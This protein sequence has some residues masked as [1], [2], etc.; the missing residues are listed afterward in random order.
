MAESV[1]LLGLGSMGK[2][3]GGALVGA[4]HDV[5]VW[6]RG[7][8]GRAAFA[9]RCHVAE[10]PAAAC[11]AAELVLICLSN[12]AAA[13]EVLEQPGV[14]A[15]LAGRTLVQLSTATPEE[16]RKFGAWAKANGTTYLDAKIAVTPPQIGAPMT[17]IFY[18]GSRAAFGRYEPVLKCLA[19]KTV[20]AGEALDRAVMGDFAFLSVYFA[21]IIGVLHGAAFCAASGM[22]MATY[23]DLTKSFLHEV[24]ERC[25]AFE[26]ALRTGDHTN[27]QSALKTDLAGAELMAACAESLGLHPRFCDAITAILRDGVNRGDAALDTSALIDTFLR[28]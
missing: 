8:A 11:A 16:A 26:V 28:K 14:A 6:N 18:A 2:M 3:L 9:G 20:F 1:A 4:G 13:Y 24:G 22:D 25:G 10:S 19:G 21:G 7:A 5:T 15:A 17:V 27:V 12:Y 23:F